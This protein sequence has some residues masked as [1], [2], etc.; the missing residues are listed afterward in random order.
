MLILKT[1]SLGFGLCFVGTIAYLYLLVGPIQQGKATG[2]TLLR[3]LTIQQPIYW[4]GV[5][6]LFAA[7]FAFFRF[8]R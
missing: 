4:L 6:V 2:L 7:S 8:T 5:A 3:A 1:V